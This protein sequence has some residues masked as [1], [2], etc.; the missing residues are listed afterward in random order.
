MIRLVTWAR[1]ATAV[2]GLATLAIVGAA[3]AAPAAQPAAPQILVSDDGVT[4]AP[5]LTDGLFDGLG[6]LIPGESITASLWVRNPS[7]TDGSLRVSVDALAGGSAVFS[8]NVSIEA[9]LGVDSWTFSLSQLA[10][11]GTV[12]PSVPIAAGTTVRIDFTAALAD[13]VVGLE[14][15][16]ESAEVGLNVAVRDARN[17]FP[18]ERCEAPGPDP[19]DP[20]GGGSA[21]GTDGELSGT[22]ANA[23][24]TIAAAIVLLVGG[25]I[26]VVTRRR[27]HDE[28][29]A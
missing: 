25:L 23:M 29:D 11:C 26:I 6:L 16:R 24:P 8:Q 28:D 5:T 1:R 18:A 27:R 14:A 22:G 21:G 2:T 12:I 19:A 10:E 17:P 20:D 15:Q 3:V 4:F 13:S 9:T 7:S